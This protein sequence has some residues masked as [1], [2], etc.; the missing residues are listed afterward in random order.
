MSFEH[1]IDVQVFT[2]GW[3]CLEHSSLCSARSSSSGKVHRKLFGNRSW[4]HGVCFVRIRS[5]G[6]I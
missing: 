1:P 3:R 5:R 2:V 6:Q 4:G